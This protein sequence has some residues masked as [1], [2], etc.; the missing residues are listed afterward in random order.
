MFGC[1]RPRSARCNRKRLQ[2]ALLVDPATGF[3]RRV[4][5]SW[6]YLH[7]DSANTN[8][9]SSSREKETCD[10]TK[11]ECAADSG[12]A[13]AGTITSVPWGPR[14]EAL[15]QRTPEKNTSNVV[16]SVKLCSASRRLAAR[17]VSREHYS[18]RAHRESRPGVLS[19]PQL[20]LN[21]ERAGDAAPT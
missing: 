13:V 4:D 20:H 9:R 18:A 15:T 11:C 8:K 5:Y 1:S 3:C 6:S 7:N 21:G 17:L 2:R 16:E 14:F 12:R 19:A 10:A